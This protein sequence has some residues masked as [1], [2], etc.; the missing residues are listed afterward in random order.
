MFGSMHFH[1]FLLIYIYFD[2]TNFSVHVN[3]SSVDMNM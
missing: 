2:G 1:A 3:S